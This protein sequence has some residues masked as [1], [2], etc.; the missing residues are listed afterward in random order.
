MRTLELCVDNLQADFLYD[1]IQPVQTDLIQGLWHTL[2]SSNESIAHVAYR[3]LGKL[4]GTN[5]KMMIEPQRLNY[6]K[7]SN[8]CKEFNGPTIKVS[9]PNYT[10]NIEVSLEKVIESCQNILKSPVHDLFY[11]RHAFKIVSSFVATLISCE[12]DKTS[13]TKFFNE[14][15]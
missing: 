3:V 6:N 4:G 8:N 13:V 12:T 5:R 15:K 10:A 11:K 9:F 2:H 1:H 14:F 7:N